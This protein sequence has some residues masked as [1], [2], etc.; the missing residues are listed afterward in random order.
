MVF[1]IDN[2]FFETSYQ[3]LCIPVISSLVED[4]PLLNDWLLEHLVTSQGNAQ[5]LAHVVHIYLYPFSLLLF[6]GAHYYVSCVI[7]HSSVICDVLL[8]IESPF[9]HQFSTTLTRH[10]SLNKLFGFI[11]S[12]RRISPLRHLDLPENSFI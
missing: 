11:H 6:T 10:Q 8:E 7:F 3:V 4:T 9:L 2:E 1:E 12:Y 5:V